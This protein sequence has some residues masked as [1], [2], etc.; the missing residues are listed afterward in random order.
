MINRAIGCAYYYDKQKKL[1]KSS[2]KFQ[3][4]VLLLLTIVIS[5]FSGGNLYKLHNLNKLKSVIVGAFCAIIPNVYFAYCSFRFTGS[6]NARKV[7]NGIYF[8]EA[9]KF[10][11][12]F[13]LLIIAYSIPGM[14]KIGVL[15]GFVA[16]FI[17]MIFFPMFNLAGYKK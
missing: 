5:I 4:F 9:I 15:I 1:I 17:S 10:I 2:I 16:V 6:R 14:D 7:L 3:F 8:A 13:C 11:L 12:V